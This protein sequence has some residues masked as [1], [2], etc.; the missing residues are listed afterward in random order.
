MSRVNVAGLH[1]SHSWYDELMPAMVFELFGNSRNH[2]RNKL[3]RGCHRILEEID[4]NGIE[5]FS[6]C[7]IPS[8]RLLETTAHMSHWVYLISQVNEVDSRSWSK[9]DREFGSVRHRQ[10]D[11]ISSSGLLSA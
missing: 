4:N 6:Q 10:V 5:S 2:I 3:Y 11:N 9:V 1:T 7:G 8:E